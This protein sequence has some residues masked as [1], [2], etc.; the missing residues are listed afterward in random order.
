MVNFPAMEPIPGESKLAIYVTCVAPQI[1][2]RNIT[3][4]PWNITIEPW[5]SRESSTHG[6][7]KFSEKFM[8]NEDHELLGFPSFKQTHQ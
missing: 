3:I 1:A 8:V 2:T 4:E 7:V 6:Q 5:N